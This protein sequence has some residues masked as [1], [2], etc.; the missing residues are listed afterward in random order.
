MARTTGVRF[1][2]LVCLL[3]AMTNLWTRHA[4]FNVDAN[5]G[6]GPGFNL[7]G[8]GSIALP[9]GTGLNQPM[10]AIPRAIGTAIG[11]AIPAGINAAA[12][13]FNNP[14]FVGAGRRFSGGLAGRGF[15]GGFGGPGFNTGFGN[16]GFGGGFGNRGFGGGFGNRGFGGGF[17]NP[18]FGGGFGNPGFAGG[19][20]GR[21]F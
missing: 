9:A 4:Q 19:F 16:R 14:G 10:V 21:G 2:A 8:T 15:G 6:A 20:G 5:F 12:A 11:A 3:L 17:G 1:L 18:G 7:R 13:G